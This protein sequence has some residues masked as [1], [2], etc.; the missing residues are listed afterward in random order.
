MALGPCKLPLP[1]FPRFNTGAEYG[2][3]GDP[4]PLIAGEPPAHRTSSAPHAP[5][6]QLLHACIA[7]G[8][9]FSLHSANRTNRFSAT[10]I[11]TPSPMIPSIPMAHTD[12]PEMLKR[13]PPPGA[14]APG[15]LAL[16]LVG[17]GAPGAATTDVAAALRPKRMTAQPL[18]VGDGLSA[19]AGSCAL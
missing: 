18:Q 5:V 15:S 8:A 16:A 4:T 9:S 19:R 3:I 7:S 6:N 10:S 17:A 13:A 11:C 2:T 1:A 12:I 14:V